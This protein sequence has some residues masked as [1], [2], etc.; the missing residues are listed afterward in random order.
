[1]SNTVILIDK[2]YQMS[3]TNAHLLIG[4]NT[5]NKIDLILRAFHIIHC[6]SVLIVMIIYYYSAA[7]HFFCY[8]L[9]NIATYNAPRCA[10]F[11]TSDHLFESPFTSTVTSLTI[12]VTSY[13]TDILDQSI[14]IKLCLLPTPF[15]KQ[16][17]EL[18]Y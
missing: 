7:L 8:C 6:T 17:I 16:H 2:I 14:T 12:I 10:L 5:Y 3:I 9:P 13:L 11:K 15:S 4:Y 1:M 18:Y